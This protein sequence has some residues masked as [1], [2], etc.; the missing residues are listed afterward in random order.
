MELLQPIFLWGMFG[1]IIPLLIHLWNGRRGKKLAWAASHWLPTSTTQPVQ[2][3]R[4]DNWLLLFLRM[5]L[6]LLI[7]MLLSQ[8]FITSWGKDNSVHTLH[9]V[10]PDPALVENF[11]FELTTAR[12]NGEKLY[13]LDRELSPINELEEVH[14]L[15]HNTASLQHALGRLVSPEDSLNIYLVNSSSTLKRDFY[16]TPTKP[17]LKL[18]TPSPERSSQII[19]LTDS[20]SLGLDE[21]GLLVQKRPG[22]NGEKELVWQGKDFPTL[23]NRQSGNDSLYILAALQ[24]ITEVYDMEFPDVEDQEDAFIIFDRHIPTN[25]D[26]EKLYFISDS[27]FY[28]AHPNVIP[29]QDS[30][31]SNAY[32]QLPE[33][34]LEALLEHLGLEPKKVEKS[35][36]QFNARFLT[37]KDSRSPLK[38]NANGI[39]W[40]L[41]VITF[42]V[43]RYFSIRK[44][45]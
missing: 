29:L 8:L 25:I 18:Y 4:L 31:N 32:G 16:T 28:P 43:E 27:L 30:V 42:A 44:G 23:V 7:V 33:I 39:L 34:I 13:W 38:A 11:K 37:M 45:L 17:N 9:L 2:G 19:E 22:D 1:L 26:P 14:S 20:L 12:E 10:Q 5:L 24:A 21:E 3:F 15:S 35:P 40:P 41:L 36:S 6:I